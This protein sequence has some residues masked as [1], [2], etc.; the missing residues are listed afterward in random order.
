MKNRTD[1][2]LSNYDYEIPKEMIAQEPCPNRDESKLFVLDK[3]KNQIFHRKF[4]DIG[5]FLSAGDCLVINTVKVVPAR[6]MGKKESG[7]KME[8]LFLDPRKDTKEYAALVKP[9]PK[10]GKKILFDDGYECIIKSCLPNGGYLLEFNKPK[11]L[12]FM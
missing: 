12:E 3:H 9:R 1:E 2:I 6:I 11:V 10:I 7:G 8:I 4:S 5:E